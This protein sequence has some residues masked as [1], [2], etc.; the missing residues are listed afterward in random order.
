MLNHS[1]WPQYIVISKNN[2]YTF[3]ES[4]QHTRSLGVIDAGSHLVPLVTLFD[5]DN[6]HFKAVW[7][8]SPCKGLKR[9]FR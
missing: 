9:I 3:S 1:L 8:R 4:S 7:I 5:R 2:N 6:S